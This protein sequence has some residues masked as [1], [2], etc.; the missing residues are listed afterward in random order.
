MVNTKPE[1]SVLGVF[2]HL[3]YAI[4]GTLSE[5][6]NYSLQ[7]YL[8]NREFFEKKLNQRCVTISIVCDNSDRYVGDKN[9]KSPGNRI[10][11]QFHTVSLKTPSDG[12]FERV[13]ILGIWTP[14]SLANKGMYCE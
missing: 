8:S 11:I 3:N 4:W 6:V 10:S 13:P 9:V 7:S 12:T 14:K 1:A 2:T 5:H